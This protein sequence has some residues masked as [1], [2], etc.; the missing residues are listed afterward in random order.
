MQKEVELV[1]EKIRLACDR[2]AYPR[3]S[4]IPH[5]KKPT[6]TVFT[7]SERIKCRKS[8]RNMK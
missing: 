5:Y 4:L 2:A 7:I 8:G 1:R 3:Q 6:L